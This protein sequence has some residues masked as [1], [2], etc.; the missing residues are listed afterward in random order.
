MVFLAY[1][2][3]GFLTG[4]ILYTFRGAPLGNPGSKTSFEDYARWIIVGVIGALAGIVTTSLL[5]L[6]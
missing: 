4:L 3:I 6:P 2:L 5:V 1:A